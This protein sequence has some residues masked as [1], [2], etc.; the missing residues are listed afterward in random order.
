MKLKEASRGEKQ[1]NP[2]VH[3]GVF[4]NRVLIRLVEEYQRAMSFEAQERVA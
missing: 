4:L 2:R 1:L 3:P